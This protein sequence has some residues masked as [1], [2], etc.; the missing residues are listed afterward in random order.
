MPYKNTGVCRRKDSQNFIFLCLLKDLASS[1]HQQTGAFSQGF[2]NTL[3]EIPKEQLVALPL[4][5]LI[6]S[7]GTTNRCESEK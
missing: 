3:L 4:Q 6:P 7:L 1:V 2:E 5:A